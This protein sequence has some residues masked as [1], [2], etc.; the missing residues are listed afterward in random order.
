[1]KVCVHHTSGG[2]ASHMSM[3][4]ASRKEVEEVMV[5]GAVHLKLAHYRNKLVHLFVPEA[6]LV[7]VLS[8]NE[9]V[10]RGVCSLCELS[11][12]MHLSILFFFQDQAM[13][14]FDSLHSALSKEFV[15]PQHLGS[16]EL[17]HCTLQ[18]LVDRGVVHCEGVSLRVNGR[19]LPIFEYLAQV[20]RPF[21]AGVWVRALTHT[22]LHLRLFS[23]RYYVISYSHSKEEYRL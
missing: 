20:I 22:P 1:M 17:F 7:M 19:Q 4:V 6:M 15:L 8:C 11:A 12:I 14:Q 18:Q 9:D 23:C 13:C 3:G 21:V 5:K 10:P 16:H 2:G